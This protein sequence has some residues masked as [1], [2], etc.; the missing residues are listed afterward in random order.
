M[1]KVTTVFLQ[2]VVALIGIGAFVWLLWEPH[3]EGRNA[4]ATFFEI[5]FNDAFLAYAYAGSVAFFV[6]VYQAFKLLGNIRREKAFSPDSVKAARTI[7][8]CAFVIIGFIVPALAYLMIVRPEDDIAGGV[9]M[10]LMIIFIS[11]VVAAVA[12]VLEGV[13]WSGVGMKPK[14]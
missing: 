9:A 4:N 2:A 14:G 1:K 11:A 12:S 10:G 8:N 5:Y 3:L 13:L 7:R 6:A